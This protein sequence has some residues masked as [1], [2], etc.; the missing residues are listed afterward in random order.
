MFT[1]R[2]P[3][4]LQIHKRQADACL[5]VAEIKQSNFYVYMALAHLQ[6]VSD[7]NVDIAHYDYL[8]FKS[9]PYD[10]DAV[11][12]TRQMLNRLEVL[13]YSQR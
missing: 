9:E 6:E 7:L 10:T 5:E 1:I 13:C 11:A 3:N 2:E 4:V 8:Q 12:Y